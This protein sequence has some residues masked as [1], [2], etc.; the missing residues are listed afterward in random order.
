MRQIKH[1]LSSTTRWQNPY[2]AG[3]L[4]NGR[5][6]DISSHRPGGQAVFGGRF[7]CPGEALSIRGVPPLY[8]IQ[9]SPGAPREPHH[10]NIDT[11]KSRIQDGTYLNDDVLHKT[12][13]Q[14]LNQELTPKEE[15]T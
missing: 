8:A 13:Q 6:I 15:D 5:I 2:W 9:A 3:F 7:P 4:L 10:P 12:A 11:I 14:L 1:L